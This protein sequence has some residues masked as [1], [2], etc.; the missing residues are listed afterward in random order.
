M[1]DCNNNLIKNR[2]ITLGVLLRYDD[3]SVVSNQ[4]I[5]KI[6][7]DVNIKETGKTFLRVR[8]EDVSRN[9]Q[10][11]KFQIYIFPDLN[12]NP[13]G[14]DISPVETSSIEVRSKIKKN[15][16]KSQQQQLQQQQFQQHQFPSQYPQFPPQFQQQQQPS[17]Y[18]KRTAPDVDSE[19]ND[20]D[21][22]PPNKMN[23]SKLFIYSSSFFLSSF[24]F[25]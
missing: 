14:D 15:N 11:K 23:R 17:L 18:L 9:H 22:Y 21:S 5:L 7:G 20:T 2:H 13:H 19:E 6:I 1:V 8:I 24:S 4:T 3:G 10:K 16:S 12:E 25:F